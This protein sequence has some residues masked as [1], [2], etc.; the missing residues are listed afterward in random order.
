MSKALEIAEI[1][2]S[3]SVD[4]NGNLVFEA[5][6]GITA[7]DVTGTTTSDQYLLEAISATIASTAVDVFVYDTSKDSD[8]G[9]WRKRTQGTSWYNET[10][11]TAT[12]GNRK[13]FPAV[14]VIVAESNK[15]TIY[16]GDD[17]ALPMWRVTNQIDGVVPQFWRQGRSATSLYALNGKLVIG[18][19]TDTPAGLAMI[20]FAADLLFRWSSGG[21]SGGTLSGVYNDASATATLSGVLP[22]LVSTAVNDVAMTVLPNAP[23]DAATGLPVPTIAVATAG[24]VSVIKDDGTVVDISGR[25][26]LVIL[27]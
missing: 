18:I 14:A 4:G 1:G 3:L 15:V 2:N 24:G 22:A 27:T 25:R 11:G 8:G 17:P 21:T 12:R 16:D 5:G 13:E 26:W 19:A 6:V 20:D 23:I 10:L 7:L 9:A